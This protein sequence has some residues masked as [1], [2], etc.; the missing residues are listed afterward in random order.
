MTR[1]VPE[2][3]NLRDPFKIVEHQSDEDQSSRGG[4]QGDSLC[5]YISDGELSERFTAR[6]RDLDVETGR[7][8]GF[9][10]NFVPSD[11]GVYEPMCAVLAAPLPQCRDNIAHIS[12]QLIA[13]GIDECVRVLEPNGVLL[14]KCQD[15]VCSGRVR[16]QTR[17]FVGV[18][19]RAGCDLVDMFQLGGHRP[20]PPGRRQMH[21]R[22]NY[23]TLLVL[24][25]A[26]TS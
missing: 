17:E 22:R 11:Q 3:N 1:R 5:N 14:V 9:S 16:W 26:V 19:E 8:N 4:L 18:A 23:S 10:P 15:Q 21:A 24:R 20:Q 12:D 2:A 13:D 25:K 7:N 6:S